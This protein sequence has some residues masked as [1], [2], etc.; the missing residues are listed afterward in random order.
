MSLGLG[1]LNFGYLAPGEWEAVVSYRFLH[2]E[3]VFIGTAEQP[4]IKAAG[5]EPAIDLNSF[6]FSMRFGL[7]KRFSLSATVPAIHASA[8]LVHADGARHPMNAGAQ[9]ADLR[10]L[11]NAWLLDPE[12]HVDR[13]IALGVGLK[14]PTGN[15]GVADAF[16]IPGGQVSR[17]VDLALQP[18]DG[19][20]GLILEGY[21]YRPVFGQAVLYAGGFYMMNPKSLNDTATTATAGAPSP[22]FLSVAD[23]YHLRA[24]LSLSPF[25]S[26]PVSFS[27]GGRID[28]VP[29]E[30]LIGGADK[31]FRRPG[32]A[33]YLD[34]GVSF[35]LGKNLVGVQVPIALRRNLQQSV[36]DESLGRPTAGGLA[37]W[38]VLVS[39]TRRF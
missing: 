19:G 26:T 38:L 15:P 3:N 31:G 14:L 12:T 5:R 23:Q 32:Y 1:G 35:E 21:G 13:N 20:V 24:G 9:L 16:F 39:Y 30:D 34:P 7:T 28:G 22:T 17:P 2:S 37:D 6:D 27:L 25:A 33:F 36:L 11:A 29:R 10:F 18:G 8:T 4:Q